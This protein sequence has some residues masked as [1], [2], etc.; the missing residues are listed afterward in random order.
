MF[1]NRGLI[2]I[3]VNRWRVKA[4]DVKTGIV[5]GKQI[6]RTVYLWPLKEANTNKIW[7][8]QK[9]VI[10]L[11][12]AS[13]YW[14]LYVKEELIKP[15]EN[16]SSVDLGLFYWQE[17]DKLVGILACYVDDMICK[18]N[19]NFKIKVINNHKNTF[20][21]GWEETKPLTNLGTHLN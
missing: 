12:D 7:K 10:G 15:H 5:Q 4:I 21:F 11:A 13:R 6:E 18:G 3:C 2:N 16:V 14:C 19:E 8:L 1:K 17:H 20:M 9:C